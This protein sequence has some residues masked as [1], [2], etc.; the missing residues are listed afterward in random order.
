M[1]IPFQVLGIDK[2]IRKKI[3]ILLTPNSLVFDSM[4]WSF[5]LNETSFIINYMSEY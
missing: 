1:E 3:L 4:L 5:F 2:I